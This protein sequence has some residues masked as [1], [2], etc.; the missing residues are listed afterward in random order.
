[1]TEAGKR[2]QRSVALHQEIE[3]VWLRLA[4]V[5][6]ALKQDIRQARADVLREES[7]PRE[8]AGAKP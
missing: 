3:T 2:L 7:Q 8:M 5:L 1:M 6:V 4:E